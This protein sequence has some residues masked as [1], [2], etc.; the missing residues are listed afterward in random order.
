VTVII[1]IGTVLR[2]IS[3]LKFI[4]QV[5]SGHLLLPNQALLGCPLLVAALATIARGGPLRMALAD[6][7]RFEWIVLLLP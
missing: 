7:P 2:M 1:D 4:N 3:Q 5:T 6:T